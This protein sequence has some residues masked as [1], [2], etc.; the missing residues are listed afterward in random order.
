MKIHVHIERVIL[1]GV[2]VDRPRLLRGALEK[3]LTHQLT[4]G[5]LSAE[6]QHGGAAPRVSGGGIKFA[7]GHPSARL[8]TEIANAVY[9]GIGARK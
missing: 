7:E 6:F 2:A 3:E 1:E 5:G 4:E 9:R 8:G